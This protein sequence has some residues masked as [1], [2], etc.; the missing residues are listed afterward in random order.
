M[1]REDVLMNRTDERGQCPDCAPVESRRRFL[2][3]A[4]AAVAAATVG[5]PLMGRAL[6]AVEPIAK[7]AKVPEAETTVKRLFTSLTAEQ[8]A[9]CVMPFDH[10]KATQVS[11]N[12][13]IIEPT[14]GKLFSEEQQRMVHEILRG[15]TS[16]DGYER[17]IRQMSD[18]NGGFENYHCALFGEP[19]G[20]LE[21]V[22]SGRHLTIR[23]DGDSMPNAVFGGP[24]TYG[25]GLEGDYKKN[26]FHYQTEAVN[27][28]FK[29]L[30][31]KQREKALLDK[32]PAENDNKIKKDGF[33][34]LPFSEL[35]EDQQ[36]VAREAGH[37]LLS[38][39]R[40]KDIEE[41]MSSFEGNGGVDMIH[42]SFY[43]Q[44]DLGNDGEW[45]VWRYEGPTFVWHFRGAP[46]VH[47]WVNWK[48]KA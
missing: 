37:A 18:D 29:A 44:E 26:I 34:G 17:M 46:H 8:K 5:A 11:A 31:G 41:A 45:D 39:Y 28:L 35:T 22:M 32:A 25:H 23:A 30:D 3:G 13:A 36:N 43:K 15:V 40:T 42:L 48:T 16:E 6:A 12:W 1:T 47:A 14:I 4:G 38:P 9:A 21:W 2:V 24:I 7:G 33:A 27:K 19:N 20:K 10:P